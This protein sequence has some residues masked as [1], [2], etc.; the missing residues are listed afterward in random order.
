MHERIRAGPAAGG[1]DL[2]VK[3]VLTAEQ[4]AAAAPCSWWQHYQRGEPLCE[5]CRKRKNDQERAA[6]RFTTAWQRAGKLWT[7]YRLRPADYD[8]IRARQGDACG[9]C[10]EPLSE[11]RTRAFIDY[12]HACDHPGKGRFCCADCVRGILCPSCNRELSLLEDP[13]RLARAVAYLRSDAVAE[14]LRDARLW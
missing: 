4:E 6:G 3:P 14:I 10:R 2:R 7:Y 8:A 13:V 9:I 12:D 1:P 5:H 11:S